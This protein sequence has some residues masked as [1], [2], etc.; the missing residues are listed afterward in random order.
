MDFPNLTQP[1]Y[2]P[3]PEPESGSTKVFNDMVHSFLGTV[4]PNKFPPDFLMPLLKS[5]NV[6]VQE[7][8]Q[9]EVGFLVCAAIGII[10]IIFMPLV[11]AFFCC[12][13]CCNNCGGK[14]LQ[15]P[16]KRITCKRR[17]LCG[18]LFLVTIVILAGDICAFL[19]NEQ[20]KEA[21]Q[22]TYADFNNSMGNLTTFIGTVSK[23]IDI[24]VGA[25][26]QPIEKTNNSLTNIGSVL[27]GM[28]SD[29][30]GKMVNQTLNKVIDLL[31]VLNSTVGNMTALNSTFQDLQDEKNMISQ[32]LS[33]VQ[34]EI[35]T[36]LD[37]CGNF[38]SD[39]ST[40][41]LV[42]D[43]NF[44][45][46]DMTEQMQLLTNLL[47]SDVSSVIDKAYQVLSDIPDTVKNR[48]KDNI[49]DMQKQLLEIKKQTEGIKKQIPV[50]DMFQNVISMLNNASTMF[51]S[52]KS[53]VLEGSYYRW[54][55]GL[56]LCCMVLLIVLCNIF[57]MI[58]GSAGLKAHVS[59]TQRSGVSNCG[60]EFFM[61]GVG[62]SFIFSWLLMLVV[63]VLFLVGGNSYTLICIPWRDQK[64]YQL[65]DTPN[66]I[67]GFNLSNSLGLQN[68]PV[69]ISSLYSDC[70][71]DKSLWSTLKLDQ[72]F[73]LD[74]ILNISQY[75]NE[76]NA[77]LGKLNIS[78]PE[79]NFLDEKQTSALKEI[80][81]SG[82]DKLN[83]MGISNQMMTQVTKVDLSTYAN[84]LDEL[85]DKNVSVKNELKSE[86]QQLREIQTSINTR[87]QPKI[88]SVNST[89]VLMETIQSNMSTTI[90]QI[91]KDEI[92]AFMF[93]VLGYF[94]SYI[95]WIKKML[96][97]E[98]ARC[99]PIAGLLDSAEVVIC[100]YI[101]NSLNAF[102][103]SLGWCI[104]FF[105]PS[106]I[107]AV[108][109][110]KYYRRM[111]FEDVYEDY[112][113][114]MER[115]HSWVHQAKVGGTTLSNYYQ[116][117]TQFTQNEGTLTW[118]NSIRTGTVPLGNK[119]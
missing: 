22:N 92:R 1:V 24:V 93:T 7:I 90:S 84:Q 109:L 101:V 25:S 72:A 94:D 118:M 107:L 52:Y 5:H 30:L 66:L 11:G 54:I 56:C 50:A 45:M 64:L 33:R 9:Y 36:T 10:F 74:K 55:V 105:I 59:P 111:K 3:G 87:L 19:S 53:K 34:Q 39:A 48:T 91:I 70:H 106:I 44:T 28:I 98:I 20:L 99:A 60:G 40:D 46:P 102:W 82:I 35:K 85:A 76:I 2:T 14:M 18:F 104:I 79:I 62:F 75:A 8:L 43:V 15:K 97:K 100:D 16:K 88:S 12:C 73:S 67:P 31:N 41:D 83:F 110:A 4:Q 17:T 117:S 51:Y 81:G 42:F 29:N 49:S 38:C 65:L 68:T 78:L 26:E 47:N 119:H 112:E 61:A 113:I 108:K 32:N 96:T 86:A 13:R 69:N 37:K 116:I 114:P 58:L 89:I 103:F 115:L 71:N 21:V 63:L 23:D 57:G 77:T 95:T 6:N 80:S 27:G